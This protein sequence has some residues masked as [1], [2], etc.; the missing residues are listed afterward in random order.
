MTNRF[1]TFPVALAVIVTAAVSLAPAATA[2]GQAPNNR[3]ATGAAGVKAAPRTPWG[4]PDLQGTWDNHTITPLERPAAFAGREFLT[5][6]EAAELERRAVVENTDEARQDGDRDVNTAYNDFWW[7]RATTVVGTKRTS[8]IV[9]PKDGKIP[10][11]TPEAQKR[12]AVEPGRRPLRATGSFEAGRGADSW[13]D[14]SLWERCITQGLP[15]IASGAYNSNVGIFQ[16]PDYVVIHHE[17]IHENRI[18][19]IDGRP[20]LNPAVRQWL[21]DSRGHW[22]GDTL[23]VNTKNFSDRTNFRGSTSGLHMIERFTR[24][25]PDT[26][27]YEVTFADPSTWTR[28]WT[29]ENLWMKSRGQIYEYACHEG[30]Y[31]MTGILSGARAQEKGVIESGREGAR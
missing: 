20:H 16:S 30:N 9:D 27:T 1:S 28:P 13:I 25:A 4:H 14:R 10:A 5:D 12:Q 21:G 6:E 31:G 7:D 23:V 24:V 2:A 18:I 22:E 3:A 26:L 17:M 11:L 19:P 8:L 29:A 15:R